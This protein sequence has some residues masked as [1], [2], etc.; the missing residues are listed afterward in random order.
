MMNLAGNE[1]L[2]PEK[3]S[4]SPEKTCVAGICSGTT[5][6]R[7]KSPVQVKESTEGLLWGGGGRKIERKS[8][9]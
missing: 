7:S 9:E 3:R 2:S 6:K 1:K 5:V 8:L 4:Q